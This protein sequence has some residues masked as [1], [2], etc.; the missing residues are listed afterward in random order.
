M[1]ST[2]LV[3]VDQYLNTSFPD[4]DREYVDGRIVER[5]MGEVDHADLQTSI[6]AYLR[7]HYR[8]MWSG[9][10]VRVQV[11]KTRFRV[12][13]ITVVAGPRPEG[14]IITDPPHLVVEVLSPDD[15]AEDVQEK[16]NDYLAFGVKFVW[17]VSP[18]SRNGWIHTARGSHAA[19]DGLLT[20][21]DPEIRL[22]LPE[23]FD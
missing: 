9:V 2:T 15:R 23:M 1:G 7:T 3:S 13:D 14:H 4:G 16:I 5:H 17:V 11:R 21:T 12:P 6:V 8:K 20:T 18:R 10:E 22:P 19:E